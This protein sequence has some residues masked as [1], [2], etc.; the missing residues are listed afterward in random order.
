MRLTIIFSTCVCLFTLG[1]DK[2]TLQQCVDLAI[3]NTLLTASENQALQTNF[4]ERKFHY[5]TCLPTI[6]GSAGANTY[7]GRRVDPYTNTFSTNMVNAQS[8]GLSSSVTIFNGLN[9]HFNRA[10]K[11]IAIQRTHVSLEGKQNDVIIRVI[12]LYSELCKQE[13]QIEQSKL[14]VKKYRELQ[15][16]QIRLIEGGKIAAIDTL[17]SHN[18]ILDETLLLLNLESE[19]HLK[20]IELNYLIGHPLQTK[21]GYELTSIS[22]LTTLPLFSETFEFEQLALDQQISK[23]RVMAERSAIMPTVSMN[24]N[25]GT[26]FSTNNKDYS[27]AGS[28]TK[29]YS[30]QIQQNLYEGIGFYLNI[31]LFNRGEWFKTKQLYRIEQ[32][33]LNEAI[34]LKKR[35]LEKRTLE[36]EQ[37][38][39]L[40]K[41]VIQQT[42]QI[43]ANLQG[44]Y[45][46]T[47]LLYQE[48]RVTY[49]EVETVFLDWQMKS[50]ELETL[51]LELETLK[52]IG[53]DF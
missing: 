46:K 38:L 32:L 26:G 43:V 52:L 3:S 10:M 13:I 44:I 42:T 30:Q 20:M 41:A 47:A 11:D 25:L 16:I 7:F 14:R 33:A 53:K 31:P 8:F 6:N 15:Q 39:V 24:G 4:I 18:S 34:E 51:K 50:V 23:N 17:K 1:Q 29:P 21:H 37:Q 5:W 48:G 2:I 22:A 35:E 19:Q 28:P 27:I 49:T 45:D 36:L 12:E 9:H 40:K